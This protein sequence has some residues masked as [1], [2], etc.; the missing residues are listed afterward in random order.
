MSVV[1][2]SEKHE[3]RRT[4]QTADSDPPETKKFRGFLVVT[5]DKTDDETVVLLDA[6]ARG[7]VPGA[8]HPTDSRCL[9][10][11]RRCLPLSESP[12]AWRVLFEYSS[13]YRE[14]EDTDDPVSFRTNC[15]QGSR[16]IMVPHVLDAVT[17]QPLLNAAGDPPDPPLMM[18]ISVPTLIVTKN[19]GSRPLFLEA[20]RNTV[21]N[22]A[23]TVVG[24]TYPANTFRLR[25][26]RVGDELLHN[27][28]PY[29]KL[30]AE[31]E[32]DPAGFNSV[33]LNDGRNELVNGNPIFK[34]PICIA[35]EPVERPVPLY[36]NGAVIPATA[37]PGAANTRSASRYTPADYSALGLPAI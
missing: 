6:D 15:E 8:V 17:G 30:T 23:L 34:Q 13:N 10:L 33:W 19:F 12:T 1:K 25:K 36:A 2:F 9:L 3:E 37:L 22:A 28:F 18:E 24:K 26:H 21:N 5:D 27:L 14:L 11:R 16:E 20:F 4:I 7:F 31:F 29:Y 35:G 32:V